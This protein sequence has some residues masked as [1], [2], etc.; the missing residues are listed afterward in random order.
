MVQTVRGV[1]TDSPSPE[2][3]SPSSET[4]QT[5][6]FTLRLKTLIGPCQKKKFDPCS[7]IRFFSLDGLGRVDSI[8]TYRSWH[9]GHPAAIAYF[10]SVIW[11]NTPVWRCGFGLND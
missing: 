5:R 9:T 8:D 7:G 3:I 2:G 10:I 11:L 1:Y 4:S 6:P